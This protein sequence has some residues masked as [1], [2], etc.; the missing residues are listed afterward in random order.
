MNYYNQNFCFNCGDKVD[1]DD[2]EDVGN[3]RLWICGN[4][5]CEKELRSEQ[6]AYSMNRLDWSD[7]EAYGY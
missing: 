6:Y 5:E 1:K 3:T 2:Y 7:D 4:W